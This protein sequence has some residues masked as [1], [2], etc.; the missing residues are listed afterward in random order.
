MLYEDDDDRSRQTILGEL[1]DQYFNETLGWTAIV[2]QTTKE[3]AR[4]WDYGVVRILGEGE[5]ETWIG[6][7]KCRMG[8]YTESFFKREGWL[9]EKERVA[10]LTKEFFYSGHQV[11]YSLLTSDKVGYI[12]SHTVLIENLW[13]MKDA[14]QHMMKDDHGRKSANKSGLIVPLKLMVRIGERQ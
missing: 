14:S 10:E 8:C 1:L 12:I 7:G 11:F 5:A 4:S 13:G 2:S 9:L 3:E 6:E